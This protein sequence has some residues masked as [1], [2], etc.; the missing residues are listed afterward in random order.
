MAL[1]KL[2]IEPL[3]PQ[4]LGNWAD[5]R[6]HRARMVAW[7]DH[8][9]IRPDFAAAMAVDIRAQQAGHDFLYRMRRDERV[10]ML[11]QVDYIGDWHAAEKAVTGVEVRDPTA[12]IDVVS[13]CFGI[14]RK[15]YLAEGTDRSLIRRAMWGLLP[16]MVL[17]NRSN[18]L[19]TADWY[20]MLE[21]QRGELAHQIATFSQS[22]LVRRIIDVERLENAIKNW[23]A[24]GWHKQEVFKEYNLALTRGVAS[25]RF[26]RWFESAN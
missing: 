25:G 1:R 17:T 15:Q 22:A 18:G 24:G 26:L 23:P 8:A 19:Q 11:A 12:D 14:P 5:R 4:L 16:E 6:R 20:E 7:Q 2:F 10:T 3:L 13:Y 21:R 9:A